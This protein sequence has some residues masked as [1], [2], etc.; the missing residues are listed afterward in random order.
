M[1]E[2]GARNLVEAY[3]AVCVCPSYRLAPKHPFPAAVTDAWTA[4]K[5]AADNARELGATPLAGFIVGGT[6][7]GAHLATVVA[8]RARDEGMTPSLTGQF[9]AV[10]MV[11][12]NDTVPSAYKHQNLSW[13]ENKD[14]PVLPVEAVQLMMS[15]YKPDVQDARNFSIINHPDGHSHLPRTVIVA[16]CL[17]PL[18]DQAIIYERMLREEYHVETE[19]Y[20]YTGVPHDHWTFFPGL[21]KS[22]QFRLDQVAAYGW[23]LQRPMP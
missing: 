6:S 20:L 2:I 5:W 1:E 15:A 11:C 10:P 16:D 19:L 9:L 23:L 22:K 17:D 3:G 12:S 21:A 8:H 14:A 4:L 13:E 7:A 18:R